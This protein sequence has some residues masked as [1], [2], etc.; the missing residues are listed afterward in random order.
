MTEPP[1]PPSSGPLRLDGAFPRRDHEDWLAAADA[2]LKGGTTLAS[3]ARATADGL[4]IEVLYHA[5]SVRGRATSS[6]P[7]ATTGANGSLPPWD[8]RLRVLGA[9]ATERRTHALAGLAGGASSLELDVR[10]RASADGV[11]DGRGR[12]GGDD[13]ERAA[14]PLDALPDALDGVHLE[15]IALALRTGDDAETALD[16]VLALCGARDHDP[17]ELRVELDADPLGELA[18]R[19][20]LAGGTEAA[21][22]RLGRLAGRAS[23][24]LPRARVVSIDT[25]VHHAAGATPV[26]EL[27][28]GLAAGTRALDAL[29]DAGLAP[30]RALDAIGF[31]VA[32]DADLVGGIVKL[33]A[34]ERLW[35]HALVAAGL[36]ARRPYVVAETSPRHLSRLEPWVNHLRN[37]HACTAAAIGGADVV[38]VRPHDLVDGE[39]VGADPVVADRVARNLPLLLAEEGGLLAVDDAAGGA[40]AIES[41][42]QAMAE[43]VWAALGE[44]QAAG[45]LGDALASGAWQSEVA[46]SHRERLARLARGESARV[47]V[48]RFRED[49][50]VVVGNGLAESLA[51]GHATS[52]AATSSDV[53]RAAANGRSGARDAP[54]DANAPTAGDARSLVAVRDAAPFER[55]G[56]T[57]ST[58]DRDALPAEPADPSTTRAAGRGLRADAHGGSDASRTSA[59]EADR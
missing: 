44:L 43:A 53:D 12:D 20:R 28:A 10:A 36:S 35:R 55:V 9:N 39:R 34:L 23:R 21:Y 19:G 18:R 46:R 5:S 6:S 29:L 45:D 22:E 25:A 14:L 32:L 40:Y 56:D 26:Q 15:M 24:E 59:R 31:R 27:V 57:P 13:D 3:L 11:G 42:T 41:S 16:A 51:D 4:P 38:V 54:T 17:A 48:T 30:E 52:I 1:A 2:S 33:R 49:G 58:G 47:A 8:N 37:V 7:A 50:I